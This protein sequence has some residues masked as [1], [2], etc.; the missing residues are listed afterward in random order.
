[1]VER[2]CARRSPPL[3]R[4]GQQNECDD[5]DGMTGSR[6]IGTARK[7][8]VWWWCGR[9]SSDGAERW[10]ELRGREVGGRKEKRRSNEKRLTGFW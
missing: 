2:G 10:E 8:V 6:P 4:G 1:M 9:S 7:S 5:D 3:R